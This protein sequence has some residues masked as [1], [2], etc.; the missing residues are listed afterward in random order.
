[1]PYADLPG[2]YRMHYYDDYIGDPWKAD[3]VETVIMHHGQ[4]K[5]GLLLYGWVP[6]LAEQYRVI[7]IDGRGFGL[8]QVPEPDYPWSLE[9]FVQDMMAL[10]D[11]LGI[12]KAHYI[13]ETIGGAM[14]LQFAYAHPDRL[15]SMTTCT[16]PY[17]FA[18]NTMYVGYYN[19]VKEQG[20]EAWARSNGD[21]RLDSASA[22]PGHR[23]WYLT[24]MGKTHPRVVMET[25]AYLSTVNLEPILP[26]ITMPTLH[27]V[28]GNGGLYRE[29]G[30]KL[31]SLMQNATLAVIPG[32]SGFAQYAAPVECATVWKQWVAGLKG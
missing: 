24:E 15:L 16:A 10:M 23:E 1:M 2:N 31:V 4:G 3:E 6:P 9:G 14:G 12:E 32:V 17:N 13:G 18:G 21:V 28:G 22:D 7:R 11:H 19:I 25:L 8:S 26:K 20:T 5:S 29:R 30:E 27:I